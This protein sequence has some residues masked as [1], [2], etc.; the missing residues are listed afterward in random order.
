MN[1][2]LLLA[3]ESEGNNQENLI[4]LGNVDGK[5]YFYNKQDRN[6]TE[7]RTYCQEQGMELATVD[8]VAQVEFLREQYNRYWIAARDAQLPRALSWD[9]TNEQVNDIE[10]IEWEIIVDDYK[11]CGAYASSSRKKFYML[12]CSYETY[13]LCQANIT[14]AI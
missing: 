7:S 9:A 5:A 12:E 8:S 3:A 4:D 14:S 13:V 1:L 10:G 11:L 6:W 2:C